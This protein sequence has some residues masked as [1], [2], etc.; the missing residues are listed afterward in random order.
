[1]TSGPFLYDDDPAPL[2]TGAPQ[3]SGKIMVFI[4]LGTV[5]AAFLAVWG[6][7]AL[8][9]TPGEQATEVT[10][11]FLAALAADDTETAHALL[12]EDERARLAPDEIAAA[13]VGAGSPELGEPGRDGD[14]RLVPVTWDDGTTETFTVIGQDGLRVCGIA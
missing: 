8:R 4:L 1:M 11:V 12:C 2:H 9:G 3:R 6:S 14:K 13:Y 5:V 7:V 10:G